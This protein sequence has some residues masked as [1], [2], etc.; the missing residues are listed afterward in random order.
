M[1]E[2]LTHGL[3]PLPLKQVNRAENVQR[4]SMH[5]RVGWEAETTLRVVQT[6]LAKVVMWSENILQIDQ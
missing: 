3:I 2:Y 4:G 1:N 6:E 5:G